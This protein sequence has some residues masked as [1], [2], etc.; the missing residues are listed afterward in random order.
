MKYPSGHLGLADPGMRVDHLGLA[1]P[2]ILGMGTLGL[3]DP[4]EYSIESRVESPN[5][6]N[7][8]V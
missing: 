3:A 6:L 8:P 5:I 7:N 1:D 2:G 4:V